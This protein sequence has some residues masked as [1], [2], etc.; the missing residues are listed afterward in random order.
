[1]S[2]VVSLFSGC[3]GLDA[4][5][6]DLGFDLIYTCDSDP[7]AIDCYSRNIDRN[8]Y[9]RDVK[10]DDFHEDILHIGNCD[11]VLG[12]FPCQGFSKVDPKSETDTR[13]MLYIKM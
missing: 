13:N 7:A 2:R 4:G 12:G 9:L 5:F 3:G 11:V 8:V 10:S 6:K 1:M